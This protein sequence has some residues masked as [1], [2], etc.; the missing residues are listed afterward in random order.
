MESSNNQISILTR[1]LKVMLPVWALLFGSFALPSVDLDSSLATVAYWLSATG[2]RLGI[3]VMVFVFT[4]FVVGRPGISVVRR[5][6]ETRAIVGVLILTLGLTA[7]VNEHVTKPAFAKP[8]PNLVELAELGVL[9]MDAN[10]FY[11]IGSKADRRAHLRTVLPDDFNAIAISD[12][13]RHEWIFETGYSFP[14]GHAFVSMLFATICVGMGMQLTRGTRRAILYA[15]SGWAVLVCYSRPILRVHTPTDITCGGL[16]G[17]LIG[18]AA[19]LVL[20]K[21]LNSSDERLDVD[22]KPLSAV[23]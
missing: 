20:S 5:R 10:D 16:L 18:A 9:K 6:F 3:P 8:R 15:I 2:G 11:A 22:V 17:I 14:S 12:R 19:F 7:A 4:T 13:V 1:L 23:S 21:V